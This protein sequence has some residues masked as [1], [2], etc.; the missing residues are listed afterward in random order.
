[1]MPVR[2]RASAVRD[3][4]EAI[5]EYEAQRTGRGSHFT[6]RVFETI[7]LV[8]RSP[9]MG[10]E[11]SPELRSLPIPRFPYVMFYRDAGDSIAIVAFFHTHR[12]PEQ[13]PVTAP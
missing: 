5:E 3:L 10:I 1:M 9:G 6:R 13:G 11:R 2:L 8:R 4:R 7:E 12:D